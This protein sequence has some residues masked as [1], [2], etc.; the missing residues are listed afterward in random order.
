[1][2]LSE[3]STTEAAVLSVITD[4]LYETEQFCR[5]CETQGLKSQAQ[6]EKRVAA[7]IDLLR[8]RVRIAFNDLFDAALEADKTGRITNVT[9][10]AHKEVKLPSLPEFSSHKPTNQRA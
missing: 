1:M 7:E 8:T 5:D 4:R 2:N 3:I 9:Y 10:T 6:T